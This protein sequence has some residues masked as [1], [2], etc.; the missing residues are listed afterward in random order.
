MN[1]EDLG[2][3][4]LAMVPVG[5]DFP[6]IREA[7][8]AICRNYPGEYWRNLEDTGGYAKEFVTELTQAG[9]LSA[10]IPEAFGGSGLPLRAGGVILEEIHASGCSGNTCH[11]QMYMMAMLVRYGSDDL[12]KRYLPGIA[13]GEIRYQSFGVTEPTTG[14]DTLKLK[15]RAV[16]DGDD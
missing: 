10:L 16:R 15:T 7:V 12:K 5:N 2:S 8:R 3:D 1:D 11:A 13:S 9:F 4:D 14:S 6:E